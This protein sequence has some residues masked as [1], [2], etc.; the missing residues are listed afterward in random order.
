MAGYFSKLRDYAY[1][2][3]NNQEV[4][5]DLLKITSKTI[6]EDKT[7][8]LNY[9]KQLKTLLWERLNKR[10]DIKENYKLIHKVLIL[11]SR[12]S[13]D[14]YLTALE[15]NRPIKERFWQPRRKI[16]LP[17]IHDLEDL[18]INDKLD[19]YFISQP[20]RTGKS[21]LVL[22]VLSWQVGMNPELA[23][24]YVSNSGTLC[25]AFYQGLKEIITD[26][27]TYCWKEIF[28]NV[29]FDAN[30][31]LNAKET[32]LEVGRIKRYHSLTCRSIDASLNG[33]CDCNGVLISDDLVSGIEEALNPERMTSVWSKVDNNMLTR[34]KETA[35]ILWIGTRWSVKDPIGVR[36]EML[37]NDPKFASLRYKIR[38]LPALN[39]N[40][41][42][43]FDYDYGVGFSTD[44][45]KRRRA[46]FENVGDIAS[47]E[48]QYQ[49]APIERSGMVFAPE[50]LTY[51]DEL[52]KD[53][54]GQ[55][56]PPERIYACCDVA[57][58]GSDFLSMPIGFQY[59]DIIYIEDWVFDNGNK[60]KTQPKV[61]QRLMMNKVASCYF[62][63]NNGGEFYA[64]EIKKAL[65]ELKYIMNTISKYAPNTISKND[66]IF[67]CSTDIISNFRFKSSARRN[68]EY[69]MAMRQM[70][71]FTILGKKQHEDACDSLAMMSMARAILFKGASFEIINRPI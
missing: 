52:P 4:V 30:S 49:G 59:G 23:N 12:Y 40:D 18:L 37:Q 66:R 32:W 21:T 46:S 9:C 68:T 24:L 13:L 44:Y 56:L 19:E 62:E 48:A 31:F 36:I 43:N 3:I 28:P 55:T 65:G 67:R 58:N 22:F 47:W 34:A 10:V 20:P 5:I 33:A 1:R 7:L 60:A 8:G 11:E 27:S 25:N 63:A 35:K 69:S 57:F 71:S 45:Y 2:N 42:S 6:N 26:T 41:E 50:S 70:F 15:W 39:E 51:Y 17:V 54:N 64:D 14:S 29:A 61:L 16:L 53:A 38:N